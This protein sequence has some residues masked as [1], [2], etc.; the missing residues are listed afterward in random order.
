MSTLAFIIALLVVLLIWLDSARAREIARALCLELCR[1]RG[2]Q[3]LDDSV[4]LVRMAPRPTRQGLRLR[5]MYRF[6]FSIDGV[7]R[8]VGHIIL[9]G[10]DFERIDLGLP[11]TGA[12]LVARTAGQSEPDTASNAADNVVP[13]RRRRR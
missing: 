10:T 2:Y 11:D 8:R 3:L 13:F 5:R 12:D 4:S 1:K 6:E 7:H 9:V